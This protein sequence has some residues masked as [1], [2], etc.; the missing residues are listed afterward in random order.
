MCYRCTTRTMI[1]RSEVLAIAWVCILKVGSKVTGLVGDYSENGYQSSRTGYSHGSFVDMRGWLSTTSLSIS[2]LNTMRWVLALSNVISPTRLE[3]ARN[4]HDCRL[5]VPVL[6][7][8]PSH[9][10]RR[11]GYDWLKLINPESKF[12][13]RKMVT[14]YIC[15]V[16]IVWSDH[17]KRT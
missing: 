9:G 1:Y 13:A 11:W 4:L 15:V 10:L 12:G 5:F 16:N 2:S 7:A 14:S 17:S 3:M 6:W 8:S